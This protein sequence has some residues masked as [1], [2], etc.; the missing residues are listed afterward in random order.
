M[1]GCRAAGVPGDAAAAGHPAAAGAG[2]GEADASGA[3]EAHH[4]DEG[5]DAGLLPALRTGQ[6]PPHTHTVCWVQTLHGHT[7]ATNCL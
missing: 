6:Q 7:M 3:A 1:I 5:S 4:P 2:E